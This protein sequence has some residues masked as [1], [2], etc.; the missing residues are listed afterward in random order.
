MVSLISVEIANVDS[1]YNPI[2]SYQWVRPETIRALNN[3]NG[4]IYNVF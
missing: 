4:F 2:I 3:F 1:E